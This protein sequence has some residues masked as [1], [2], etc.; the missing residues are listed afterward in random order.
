M[1]V[2]VPYPYP[3][4]STRRTTG[5]AARAAMAVVLCAL[6]LIAITGLAAVGAGR[7]GAASLNGATSSKGAMGPFATPELLTNP[8]FEESVDGWQRAAGQAWAGR[9]R[10]RRP[11]RPL[12]GDQHRECRGG[13]LGSAD[14]RRHTGG[15]RQLPGIGRAAVAHRAAG[16]GGTGAVALGGSHGPVNGYTTVTV[17]ARTWSSVSA[18]LDVPDRRVH[19]VAAPG[20]RAD[21]RGRPRHGCRVDGTPASG[22]RRSNR[23]PP[24]GA[25]SS[26]TN[27]ATYQSS[28]S[29]RA[30]LGTDYLQTNVAAAR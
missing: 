6:V 3:D 9:Q 21:A 19:V 8:S 10:Q 22:T 1:S 14:G 27:W 29:V 25:R 16:D 13:R 15:Q 2:L 7:A 11:G 20:V 23:A 12:P 17:T 4:H 5:R 28:S 26:G 30:P 18:D 24:S